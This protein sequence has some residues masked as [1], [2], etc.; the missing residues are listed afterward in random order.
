MIDRSRPEYPDTQTS[1]SPLDAPSLVDSYRTIAEMQPQLIGLRAM[2]EAVSV[3][4][5]DEEAVAQREHYI[6]VLG[7]SVRLADR[8]TTSLEA[9]NPTPPTSPQ[10]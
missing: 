9:T 4:P 1:R 3:R 8:M 10:P 7:S 2:L 5:E 6:R